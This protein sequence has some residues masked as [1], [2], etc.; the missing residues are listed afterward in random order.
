MSWRAR[1]GIHAAE[2]RESVRMAAAAIAAHKLRSALTL[3]GVMVGVFSIIV[4][5]TA[6]RAAQGSI[7]RELSQLG[8]NTFAVQRGPAI[9]VGGDGGWERFRRR[10][11]ITLAMG[12]LLRERATLARTVGLSEDLY[13]GEAVSLYA[14]TPPNVVLFGETPGSFLARGW[15]LAEGR[16]LIEADLERHRDVCVLG[17]ALAE[18][19]FPF[20]SAIGADIKMD[21]I[22]YEV[23][24]VLEPKGRMLGGQ[25]DQFAIVPITSGMQR[26]GHRWSSIILLVQAPNREAYT[27]T[28]EQ[29]RGLLRALRK[30]RPGQPDDFEMFSNDSLVS[31][32]ESITLAARA[33]AAVVS[34]IALLAAG[35]GIMNIMLVSVTERT[36][37]IGV[38]RAIGAKKRHIIVQFITEA[39]LLS[40]FGGVLGVA[41]GVL[42]GNIAAYLLEV[43][44]VLPVDWML[45]G[46]LICS[47]VGIGFGTYPAVR[48]AN[49][50]PIDSLRYE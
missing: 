41:A 27:D 29:V 35:I 45:F 43:P 36:R 25:Q 3:L 17:S 34:S 10:K 4:V 15:N 5:M 24:G 20:G 7:E 37:E 50:N 9:Y 14:K 11:P 26:Y 49:L 22:R 6:M 46:L 48:A 18:T 16:A 33:G 42:G 31:Q 47:L 13:A 28:F 19:L 44:L 39:V 12:Q 32:F 40:E 2:L 8:A 38:R 21:G 23:V 30:V 1:I